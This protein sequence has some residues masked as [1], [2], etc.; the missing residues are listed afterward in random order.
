MAPVLDEL[1]DPVDKVFRQVGDLPKDAGHREGR[2]LPGVRVA[3]SQEAV[4]VRR[5]VSGDVLCRQ[6]AD[7]GQREPHDKL[8]LVVQVVL[9]AVGHQGQH[10][11]VLREQQHETLRGRRGLSMKWR[12][13]KTANGTTQ[14]DPECT[15]KPPGRTSSDDRGESS[16]DKMRLAYQVSDAL[17]REGLACDETNALHLAPVAWISQHVNKQKLQRAKQQHG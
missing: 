13:D 10:L 3:G 1:R 4:D 15:R 2:L 7:A 9:D 12:G 14:K 16:D 17:L 11:L 8:V 6:I 5:E